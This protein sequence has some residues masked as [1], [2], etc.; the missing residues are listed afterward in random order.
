MRAGNATCSRCGK[1]I[2]PDEPWDLGRSDDDRRLYS[3]PEHRYCNRFGG[4]AEWWCPEGCG[5]PVAGWPVGRGDRGSGWWLVES[6]SDL[7]GWPDYA[8][9]VVAEVVRVTRWARPRPLPSRAARPPGAVVFGDRFRGCRTSSS[10][11]AHGSYN[12]SERFSVTGAGVTRLVEPGRTSRVYPGR[13]GQLS[14]AGSCSA[15]RS[16]PGQPLSQL[17]VSRGDAPCR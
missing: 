5:R 8:D 12:G 17:S 11:R 1:L 7:E 16:E 14:F 15:R 4:W 10:G 13:P 3:G 9:A 2:R 6:G